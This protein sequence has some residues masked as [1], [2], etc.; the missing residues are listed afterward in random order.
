MAAE[1]APRVVAF[2]FNW[3]GHFWR[4]AATEN[5]LRQVFPRVI[6]INSEEGRTRPGWID[7]GGDA[8]FTRQFFTALDHFD[9]DVLFHLQADAS[10]HDWQAVADAAVRC[11]RRYQWG[12]FAPNVEFTGWP[13][14]NVDIEPVFAEPHLRLVANTD[15]TC[16][17]IARPILDAFRERRDLFVDNRYGWGIDLTMAA[18]AFLQGRPV[19]RDYGNTVVHRQGRGYDNAA[20]HAEYQTFLARVDPELRAMVDLLLRDRQQALSYSAARRGRYCS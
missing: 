6:V 19:L 15:C 13:A 3:R 20:A 11:W 12:V 7:V 1:E 16:W 18:L 8:Y 10:Y 2:V 4:A 9:G 5:Q 17:L 14:A